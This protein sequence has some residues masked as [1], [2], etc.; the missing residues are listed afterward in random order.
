MWDIIIEVGAFVAPFAAFD[1]LIVQ[2]QRRAL[3]RF[4]F[5]EKTARFHDFERRVIVALISIFLVRSSLSWIRVFILSFTVA[6]AMF[7]V[8]ILRSESDPLDYSAGTTLFTLGIIVLSS[9]ISLP[10]DYFS[11]LV[12]KRLFV[13][14]ET[15]FPAS[16]PLYFVDICLSLMP[17][18]VIMSIFYAFA[19]T[20]NMELLKSDTLVA[21]QFIGVLFLTFGAMA[22][23]LSSMLVSLIQ[24]LAIF[25]STGL[26]LF[27]RATRLSGFALQRSHIG[28][29]PL[30]AIG[31]V[32]GLAASLSTWLY[33]LVFS[34]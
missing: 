15:V 27:F 31:L 23:L 34:V 32:V 24:G 6:T 11:L 4:V 12:T 29:Y 9:G 14:R 20:L 8:L 5:G 17:P 26:H 3:G 25:F 19:N 16:L 1:Q 7:I 33:D 22:N 10:C 28:E 2:E 18:F 13:D 30:T 21:T